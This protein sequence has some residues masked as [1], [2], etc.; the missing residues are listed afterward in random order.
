MGLYDELHIDKTH[1]PENLKDH[2]GGWQTKSYNC[3]L[4]KLIITEDGDLI[5][6]PNGYSNRCIEESDHT[7]E[8]RF[9]KYI[10]DDR[11]EFVAFF[12]KGK[13]LKLIKI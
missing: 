13:M 2:E 11:I 7:G 4:S 1:L 8:I 6:D 12:E 9:Y 5:D 10:G 3:Y